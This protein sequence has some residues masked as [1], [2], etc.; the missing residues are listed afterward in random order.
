M[1]L[2]RESVSIIVGNFSPATSHFPDMNEYK[3]QLE[4]KD[5]FLFLKNEFI[6]HANKDASVGSNLAES[7]KQQ[8][9]LP[10]RGHLLITF[11]STL[12]V[13]LAFWRKISRSMAW[14]GL[15]LST[16]IARWRR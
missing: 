6:N 13:C 14:T 8:V 12:T 3:I 16:K 1:L 11:F 10:S 2:A 9:T 7:V 15:K 5:D 4:S